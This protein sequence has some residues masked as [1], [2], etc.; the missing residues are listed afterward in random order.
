MNT[1]GFIVIGAGVTLFIVSH[2]MGPL[3]TN[4]SL[5]IIG[6]GACAALI[7]GAVKLI[8]R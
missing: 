1:K 7:Y 8:R 5:A 2:L 3:G 6:I 4:P